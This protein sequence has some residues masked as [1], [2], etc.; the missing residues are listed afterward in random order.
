MIRML[1]KSC[2]AIRSNCE[3]ASQCA[4]HSIKL[5]SH[6]SNN[7]FIA[8]KL[9]FCLILGQFV[10]QNMP[11]FDRLSLKLLDYFSPDVVPE[12]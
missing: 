4:W 7:K 6:P 10:R 3:I 12:E 1:N 8:G 5:I 11:N 9:N 2:G